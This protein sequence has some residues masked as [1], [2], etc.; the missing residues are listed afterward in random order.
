MDT[1]P[2]TT[3]RYV[4]PSISEKHQLIPSQSIRED[5]YIDREKYSEMKLEAQFMRVSPS[6]LEAAAGDLTTSVYS[7]NKAIAITPMLSNKT[8]NYFVIR[9]ADYQ[10]RESASYTVKLPTSEGTLS[11]PQTGGTLTLSGRDSK[12][13]VT[14]YSMGDH[15]LLYSTAEI[16]TWQKFDNRTLVIMYGGPG[17]LHEFALKNAF[18]VDDSAGSTLAYKQSKSSVIVQFTPTPERQVI[19][20]GDLTV[21]M[22]GK[23]Y[24]GRKKSSQPVTN[25]TQTATVPTATGC[26]CSPRAVP[27]TAAP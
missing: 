8:G 26:P 19:R 11:I 15:T 16:L 24:I 18:G 25:A 7:D 27:R 2:T 14:D 23:R 10:S 3:A 1:H 22:L 4:A 12:F 13:H 20:F 6:I 21:F 17:E 9:H 5:R